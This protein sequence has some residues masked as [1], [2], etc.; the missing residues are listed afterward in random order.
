MRQTAVLLISALIVVFI[1]IGC[2]DLHPNLQDTSGNNILDGLIIHPRDGNTYRY[3]NIGNQI[4]MTEN[5]R[6]DINHDSMLYNNDPRMGAKYGRLYRWNVAQE[7]CPEGWRL[8]T[9]EEW[10]ELE[11]YLGMMPEEANLEGKRESGV[12]GKK[13]KSSFGWTEYNGK[14]N[15]I[16]ETGFCALPG[17]LRWLVGTFSGAGEY[18]YFCTATPKWRGMYYYRYLSADQDGVNRTFDRGSYAMSVRCV[19]DAQSK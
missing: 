1:I 19:K 2:S 12:V 4:W 18:S 3:A 6:Y 17:G 14:G 15:G 13:L 9:D 8:P 16:D 5:L 10:K 11:I 7:A